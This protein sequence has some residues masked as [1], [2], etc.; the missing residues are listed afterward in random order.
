[1]E[2][3]TLQVIL[4][5]HKKWLNNKE[6]GIRA[7]LRGADLTG[8]RLTGARLTRADLRGADLTGARLTGARLT[9]A[10]L[11]GA[12]LRGADLTGADLDFSSWPLWCGSTKAKVDDRLSRQ[13]VYHAICVMSQAQRSE[14][15]K[16]PIAWANGFHRIGE[17]PQIAE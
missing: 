10:D 16:D 9:R 6:G 5:N 4:E 11:R 8:A 12:D 17:L 3:E 7:D 13:L 15:L 2:K 14:F 1:M